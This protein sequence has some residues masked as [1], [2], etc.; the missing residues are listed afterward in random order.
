MQRGTARL[1]GAT[2][3]ALLSS[4]AFS[5]AAQDGICAIASN[6]AAFDHHKV[7]LEGTITD[8]N[9]KISGKGN[10]Y[11][12]FKLQDPSGCGALTVFKFNR[13]HQSVNNGNQ[14]RVEG[15]FETVHIEGKYRFRNEVQAEKVS[16][17]A[18]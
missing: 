5:Y 8:L 16:L 12:T 6:P 3:L 10:P 11:M 13:E 4:L 9:E 17:V 14:V 1:I 18:H 7:N 15:V 2:T